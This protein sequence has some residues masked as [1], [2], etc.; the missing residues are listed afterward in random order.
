MIH[1]WLANE[2]EKPFVYVYDKYWK[3]EKFYISKYDRKDVFLRRISI[4][5]LSKVRSILKNNFPWY[6]YVNTPM[7]KLFRK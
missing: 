2:E 3:M 5:N 4:E 1:E 6:P 7:I